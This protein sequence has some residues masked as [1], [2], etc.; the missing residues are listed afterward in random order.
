MNINL[1]KKDSLND[2]LALKIMGS[3]FTFLISNLNKVNLYI[4][5]KNIKPDNILIVP[6]NQDYHW[7]FAMIYSGRVYIF[8]SLLPN[9][10]AKPK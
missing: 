3:H 8:D 2:S 9:L 4:E 10:K 6:I 7:F 1:N 5:K